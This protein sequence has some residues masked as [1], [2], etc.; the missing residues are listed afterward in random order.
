MHRR[1]AQGGRLKY[2]QGAP[3]TLSPSPIIMPHWNPFPLS[4]RC[5]VG[6]KK[7]RV[8]FM[9]NH[10][11][12]EF[13]GPQRSPKPQG[14][15]LKYH[16]GAPPTLSPSPII[17]PHWYPFPLSPR[18]LVGLKNIPEFF[19][20]KN[21]DFREILGPQR[22]PKPQGGRLKYHQGAPPTLS[23]SPIIMP[24]WNPFP[25]SPRCLVGLKKISE[26][27]FMKNHDFR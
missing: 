16:Q 7:I 25:L 21:H 15:R 19:F 10:D 23:P 11:F 3:P 22:S 24:H 6:L 9:E 18:C 4:P 2:H 13:L 26:F 17:M 20:M 12:R 5:L 27:F 8:F 1:Q 14:G